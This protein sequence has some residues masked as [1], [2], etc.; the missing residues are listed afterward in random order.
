MSATVSAASRPYTATHMTQYQ[1]GVADCMVTASLEMK[2]RIAYHNGADMEKSGVEKVITLSF[3]LHSLTITIVVAVIIH[4]PRRVAARA[5]RRTPEE[6]AA[7]ERVLARRR[8]ER[9]AYAAQSRKRP[10]KRPKNRKPQR[11]PGPQPKPIVNSHDAPPPPAQRFNAID[12]IIRN[13]RAA[14]QE[15]EAA[16]RRDENRRRGIWDPEP[17]PPILHPSSRPLS[18]RLP[19]LLQGPC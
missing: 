18:P 7:L 19:L 4:N 17:L 6:H 14:E 3:R 12:K 5:K 15:L 8:A 13:V 16:I 11:K 10:Q 9:G 1:I 2:A